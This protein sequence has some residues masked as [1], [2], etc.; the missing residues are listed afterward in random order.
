MDYYDKNQYIESPHSSQTLSQQSSQT[1]S[2]MFSRSLYRPN[3]GRWFFWIQNNQIEIYMMW[4][5]IITLIILLLCLVI[6]GSGD[7]DET[8]RVA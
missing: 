4:F 2:Q 6:S 1:L 5:L 8:L 3:V 7:R